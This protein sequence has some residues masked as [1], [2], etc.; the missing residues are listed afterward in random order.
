MTR[1]IYDTRWQE[2]LKSEVEHHPPERMN[3]LCHWADPLIHSERSLRTIAARHSDL[4]KELCS[5]DP[6]FAAFMQRPYPRMPSAEERV[7]ISRH[8]EV[9][10]LIHL[11]IET[12]YVFA[13]ILLDRIAIAIE[14]WFGT[15]RATSLSSHS[16]LTRNFERY[17]TGT[18]IEVPAGL[19]EMLGS[20]ERRISHFRD[21][22]ITHERGRQTLRI[23]FYGRG[24]EPRIAMSSAHPLAI[25][26]NDGSARSENIE[27][28]MQ[29]LGGYIDLVTQ[30][31]AINRS[32]SRVSLAPA[33]RSL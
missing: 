15:M 31:F 33:P 21:Y 7:S 30:M 2:F 17:V 18:G 5:L 6:I 13:K 16:K 19:A 9:T 1:F 26:S 28:L 10:G 11:E 27:L 14:Q 24:Q 32:R 4:L 22:Q 25:N 29:F 8:G 3:D 20:L 12:F 23:T